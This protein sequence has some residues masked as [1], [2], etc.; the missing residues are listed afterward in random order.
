MN[1]SVDCDIVIAVGVE[2]CERSKD[3]VREKWRGLQTNAKKAHVKRKTEDRRTGG[4]PPPPT[5]SSIEDRIIDLYADTP[6][7]SGL[8]GFETGKYFLDYSL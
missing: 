8:P 3:K 2:M 7:F 6:S 5:M 1:I 4:G